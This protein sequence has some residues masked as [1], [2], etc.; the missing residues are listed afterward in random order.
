MFMVLALIV[1]SGFF[2]L[3]HS[4]EAIHET[5]SWILLGTVAAHLAGILILS[6][7]FCENGALS[8]L[9]GRKRAAEEVGLKRSGAI[10]GVLLLAVSLTFMVHLFRNYE[11]GSSTVQL[12]WL[13]IGVQ[14]GEGESC[15]DESGHDWESHY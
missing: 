11:G 5:L 8:M 9:T 4:I 1:L 10:M 13:G 15:E 12:P 6:L 3:N 7:R 2:M 14:L